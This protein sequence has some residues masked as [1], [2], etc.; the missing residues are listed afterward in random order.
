MRYRVLGANAPSAGKDGVRRLRVLRTPEGCDPEAC[1]VP[2]GAGGTGRAR[3]RSDSE[4]VR[5]ERGVALGR[6][7]LSFAAGF[8]AALGGLAVF[9]FEPEFGARLLGVAAAIATGSH[10]VGLLLVRLGRGYRDE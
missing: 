5:L 10:I 6:G 4:R 9:L 7:L 1:T 3:A 8:W 2:T